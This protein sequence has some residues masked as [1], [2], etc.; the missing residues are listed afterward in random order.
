MKKLAI[1]LSILLIIFLFTK[2]YKENPL[3]IIAIANY[4]QHSSLNDAIKGIELEL[5]TQGYIKGENIEYVISDVAF[6]TALIPQMLSKLQG[7]K[8]VLII[9]M[10]TP[11]SQYAK[12]NIKD[13]PL[14]FSVVTDPVEAGLV[15]EKNKSD[16]NMTGSSDKQN[17]KIMLNFAQTIKPET[18]TF[19]IL[20]S[21]SESN[22][23]S[24]LKMMKE[25]TDK[26]NI[27]L[28]SIPITES[29]EILSAMQ[30]FK[31]SVDFIYVGS[32]GKIQPSLPLIAEEARKM[33]I[34]II[35]FDEGP[36][37]DGL[38]IASFGVNYTKVGINTGKIA[39]EIL[40]GKNIKDLPPTY[41]AKEDHAVFINTHKIKEYKIEN[42]RN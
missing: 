7:M 28:I 21:T 1:F 11:I 17:L 19:G 4:G 22:D 8:P 27:K 12:G 33:N 20:Y 5:K 6:D 37:N 14:I 41:P 42:V 26:K 23:A 24:L 15:K 35:N 34:P 10:G 39:A 40:K 30:K 18:K 9:T 3:P 36:V 31:N 16:G 29:R 32:S 2:S 38:A 13:I 25:A